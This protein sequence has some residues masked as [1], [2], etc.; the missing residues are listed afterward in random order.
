MLLFVMQ[1]S[2]FTHPAV[3]PSTTARAKN[4]PSPDFTC[5]ATNKQG[6][7]SGIGGLNINKANKKIQKPVS[8]NNIK[9]KKAA[10]PAPKK[11]ITKSN[12]KSQKVT[13][14]VGSGAPKAD[15]DWGKIALAFLTPWRNPN[16]IFL[17]LLIIVSILGKA[18]EN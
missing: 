2:A 9:A 5:Y 1:A 17:Y 11:K 6:R 12:N 16:S 14:N 10:T 18:N 8:K 3:L 13:T 4:S 15:I 7:A